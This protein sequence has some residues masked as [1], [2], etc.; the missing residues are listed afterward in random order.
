MDLKLFLEPL[1]ESLGINNAGD[2]CFSN[3]IHHYFEELPDLT[4][5]QIAIIGVNEFRG[6]P[7][8]YSGASDAVREKLYKLTKISGVRIGD[9]GNLRTGK[10]LEESY[11]RISEVCRY[12][13]SKNILPILLGGS[14]D[15]SFGMYTAYEHLEK[16][17]SIINVD[18]KIDL[19]GETASENYLERI[20][21]HEKNYLF[22]L[23]NLAHQ[24]YLVN[25]ETIDTLEKLYFHSYRV[26]TIHENI[27]DIEPIIREGDMLTFDL[28]AIKSSDFVGSKDAQPFGLT[29]EEACQ[30]AWYAG[31]NEKLSSIGF[32][33]Y[34]T[35]A[36]NDEKS[37]A[38]IVATMIWYFIDGFAN[39]KDSPNFK[40]NDFLKYVVSMP[41]SPET[42]CFF[43]SSSSG[44]W[45]MKVPV[46]G[47]KG[48]YSR[49]FI[50]PCSYS[51][52]ST[53]TEGEVPDRYISTQAR[54]I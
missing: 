15:L 36:D 23:N 42:I 40:E 27:K 41:S 25:Q 50:I 10:D 21:L 48:Y 44:K 37:S 18:Y 46:E 29:S 35:E 17:V 38:S 53:A 16:L 43:K 26:G 47:K 49:D 51:D 34:S 6:C 11:T 32:F 45:W 4:D 9:L 30:I 20:L 14:Q 33:E 2:S 31:I 28:R 24:S 7:F 13:I 3:N 12:L 8:N 22:N 19:K 1:N 39:R 5:L 54:L 52:Y